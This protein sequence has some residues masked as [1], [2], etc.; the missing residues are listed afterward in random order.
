MA[1]GELRFWAAVPFL[2][3]GLALGLALTGA[4][5]GRTEVTASSDRPVQL[6]G[7]ARDVALD[8]N[9]AYL[10]VGRRVLVVD[11][12][13]PALPVV[14]GETEALP[15]R[16]G[17]LVFDSGLVYAGY[18]FE[19]AGL[20]DETGLALIDVSDPLAPRIVS[21]LATKSR[22]SGLYVTGG[23]A[24]LA[25]STDGLW[26][27][28]VR[29]PDSP[30]LRGRL[31]A[32]PATDIVPNRSA[33][34]DVAVTGNLAVVLEVETLRNTYDVLQ[35]VDVSDPTNPRQLGAY[36]PDRF[37]T[38]VALDGDIA[39]LA[40]AGGIT[41]VSLADPRKPTVIGRLEGLP[42][43]GLDGTGNRGHGNPIVV[44]EDRAYFFG[45]LV[46]PE[47]SIW[48]ADI[49][50]PR[51]PVALGSIRS[52]DHSV[53]LAIRDDLVYLANWGG[54]GARDYHGMEIY[55]AS[56]A[57]APAA[58]GS[59]RRE[60]WHALNVTVGASLAFVAAAGN[61]LR[62][63][64]VQSPEAPRLVGAL[65]VGGQ[66]TDVVVSEELAY[67]ADGGDEAV[68]H[69]V[70]VSDR[71]NPLLVA[72]LDEPAGRAVAIERIDDHLTMAFEDGRLALWSL[73]DPRA[74]RL[75]STLR[76][77]DH[78]SDLQVSDG[79][80]LIVANSGVGFPEYLRLH[81]VDVSAPTRPLIKD[82]FDLTEAV[83]LGAPSLAF[84]AGRL[85]LSANGQLQVRELREGAT[86]RLLGDVD[87]FGPVRGM[88]IHEGYVHLV[89]H[90]GFAAVDVSSPES[91]RE[92]AYWPWPA[93]GDSTRATGVSFA[94]DCVLYAH[95]DAG[96]LVNCPDLP[97]V[98][99]P[100][101]TRR[102]TA[103]T[104]PTR[105]A[106]PVASPTGAP[107]AT[108]TPTGTVTALPSAAPRPSP[109][110]T[111]IPSPSPSP[112]PS[113]VP[114]AETPTPT[115]PSPS[116]S[117]SPSSVA[118]ATRVTDPTRIPRPATASPTSVLGTPPVYSIVLP[119]ALLEFCPPKDVY[120][121]VVLVI[122]ASTSMRERTADG[123]P[124]ID[125]A[126]EAAEVFIDGL[127][128]G[129][130]Q[131]RVAVVT[132]SAKAETL[133][134]LTD[135]PRRAGASL[136]RLRISASSRVD[137]GVDRATT[138]LVAR[139][140]PGHVHAMVVLSDGKVNGAERGRP[141]VAAR[142]ARHVGIT[143]YVVGMG[144][145]MDEQVLREMA[146]RADR[147]YSAPAPHLIRAIYIDLSERVPCPGSAYWGRR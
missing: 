35:I 142:G 40:E 147:F 14:V 125:V 81:V 20:G 27:V 57:T 43:T 73:S 6:G 48:I 83:L 135:A 41:V 136:K 5:L 105:G 46:G 59:I 79:L 124:K 108:V 36:E 26:I 9:V 64:D 97:A 72:S 110:P 18:G 77:G 61:G 51:N 119:V 31:E 141:G 56:D 120:T 90:F 54:G 116:P 91:P 103:T 88:A 114:T 19:V 143:V 144:P 58:L 76:L 96:M 49:S 115:R 126:I 25:L 130:G 94:G 104:T 12:S 53:G 138:E 78:A 8:G 52:R 70:D 139:G 106:T 62:V 32:T 92:A 127:R 33:A 85:Y 60:A 121:D 80:A 29:D 67:L 65:D 24:Y 23:L 3:V 111:P 100:T 17:Q 122:D 69:V 15:G 13:D 10:A 38:G 4:S 131:D 68:L 87:L 113:V 89:E 39:Y 37:P 75:E 123:T 7:I 137:R 107:T 84:D 98:P 102:A 82:T 42:S 74:P 129:P 1:H 117:P 34:V 101:A 55:D 44:A 16:L 109:S 95:S 21:T 22:P 66:V 133:H 132:F 2:T 50:D 140:R 28:D 112:S 146:G 45:A 145:S 11:V 134:R 30:A 128:L 93:W 63:V 118:T 99:E 86:P 47:R 71:S